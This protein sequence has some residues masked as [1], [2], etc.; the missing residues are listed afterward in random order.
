MRV[1]KC[2]LNGVVRSEASKAFFRDVVR[3]AHDAKTA[4][5][6]LCKAWIL[7]R[8]QNSRALPRGKGELVSL[9]QDAVLAIGGAV[10]STRRERLVA[11]R[12]AIFPVGFQ[13]SGQGFH[14]LPLY[15]ANAYAAQVIEHLSRCY[16]QCLEKYIAERLGLQGRT[17]RQERMAVVRAVMR[18]EPTPQ[19]P[20]EEARLLV[21]A[22]A[23]QKEYAMY[24]VLVK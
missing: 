22:R 10:S 5:H 21:P 19:L 11:L 8:H 4:A 9:F 3:R 1:I 7:Q 24:D 13:V 20:A 2:G 12:D 17:H 23:L 6:L 16:P 14:N 15:M 18:K